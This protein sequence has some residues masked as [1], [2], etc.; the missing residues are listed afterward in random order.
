L[1]ISVRHLADT[2]QETRADKEPLRHLKML[3]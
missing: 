1:C 3:V 2:G